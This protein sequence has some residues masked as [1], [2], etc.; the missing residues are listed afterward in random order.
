MA[1]SREKKKQLVEDLKQKLDDTE[2]I[3]L[4]DFR[5]LSVSDQ[6]E[7]RVKLRDT[8]ADYQV[9][10]NTLTKIALE[11]I[12]RPVPEEQLEG[13]TALALLGDDISGPTKVLLDFAKETGVLHVKGGIIGGRLINAKEVED[14]ADLPPL[15]TLLAQVIGALQGPASKLVGVLEAPASELVRTLQAPQRELALT[16]QAYA[17]QQQ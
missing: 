6:Q 1:I 2:V 4:T 5:G 3:I 17:D 11:A 8:S 9:V 12:D 13:P 14:L 7:L 15:E 16:L 10:K